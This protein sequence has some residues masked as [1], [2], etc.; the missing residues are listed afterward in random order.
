MATQPY[1]VVILCGGRGTRLK[2]ETEWR[3]KP[4]VTI[5]DRPIL[6]HIMKIY[7]HYGFTNFILCLGYKGDLIRD[8]FLNYDLKQSDLRI[9]LGSKRITTLS[10]SHDEAGWAVTLVDTG[11]ETLTGGRLKIASRY[12][13]S[14]RFLL[15]YGDGV[16]DVNLHQLQQVHDQTQRWATV[17]G[18]RPSS[19]YGELTI[20]DGIVES[21]NEKPQTHEGWINGGFFMMSRK[22][23]D[24][25]EGDRSSLE[26]ELMGKLADLGQLSVYQH[27]GFW[28]CMDTYREMELLNE[29]WKTGRAPWKVW[30]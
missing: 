11:Q 5:G 23:L 27:N 22:V 12:I 16:A 4:M 10:P 19:R 30:A 15:T 2:E 6:W 9:E 20:Q 7:A 28:Q 13:E 8:Y 1:P 18:V 24:L 3:P 21:F 17:T 14:D 29:L 25:L 26:A